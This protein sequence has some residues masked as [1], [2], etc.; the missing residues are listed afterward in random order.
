[1]EYVNLTALYILFFLI[2]F[3]IVAALFN[4]FP[5]RKDITILNFLKGI[6]LPL[7]TFTVMGWLDTQLYKTTN[8]WIFFIVIWTASCFYKYNRKK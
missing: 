7:I 8:F 6:L 1:M 4:P 2:L 3:S 5:K